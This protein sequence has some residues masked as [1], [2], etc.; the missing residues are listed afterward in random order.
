MLK[1]SL[2]FKQCFDGNRDGAI[3]GMNIKVQL[4]SELY[5]TESFSMLNHSAHLAH[6]NSPL[7]HCHEKYQKKNKNSTSTSRLVD[8]LLTIPPHSTIK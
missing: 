2:L 7:K 1:G 5:R 4:L 6:L 3:K 8:D